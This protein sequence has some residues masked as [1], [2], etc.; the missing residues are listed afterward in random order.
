MWWNKA[1]EAAGFKNAIGGKR[2]AT[3]HM[4]PMDIRYALRLVDRPRRTRLLPRAELS[5][6]RAP[7]RVLGSQSRTS[8]PIVCGSIR[9]FT[10]TPIAR[11]CRPNG[12]GQHRGRSQPGERGPCR[13]HPQRTTR[14]GHYLRQALLTLRM[15]S[16]IRHWAS[17]IT[18]LPVYK[19]ALLGDGISHAAG[20]GKERQ[21][22]YQPCLHDLH[23]Q[24]TT[25]TWCAMPTPSFPPPAKK[26][27]W[28]R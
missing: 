23:R 1:F 5:T 13:S 6:I 8:T 17:D 9:Q 20:G 22:R 10:G 3:G 19:R 18:S 28:T 15:S 27:A 11:D 16:A 21:A 2:R 25:P 26:Q 24:L 4:D 14:H 7:V 12:S